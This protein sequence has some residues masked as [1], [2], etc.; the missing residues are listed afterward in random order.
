MKWLRSRWSIH[1]VSKQWN[2]L[3]ASSRVICSGVQ[4][5]ALYDTR[6]QWRHIVRWTRE[7][8]GLFE[9]LR[10]TAYPSKGDKAANAYVRTR[11]QCPMHVC[12]HVCSLQDVFGF[13]CACPDLC[14]EFSWFWGVGGT[15][16]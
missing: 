4:L 16:D 13:L 11:S 1:Q 12:A 15:E 7:R 2:K 9:V 5:P 10:L 8:T 3:A 14:F 6:A